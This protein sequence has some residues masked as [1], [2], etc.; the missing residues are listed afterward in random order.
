MKPR[1]LDCTQVGAGKP[2][3]PTHTY[4]SVNQLICPALFG[5]R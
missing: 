2:I 1:P 4:N 3:P 5:P